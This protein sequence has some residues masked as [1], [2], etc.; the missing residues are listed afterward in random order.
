MSSC[1][2]DALERLHRFNPWFSPGG[3][4]PTATGIRGV[5]ATGYFSDESGWG[6]AGRGYV[7]ALQ[8]LRVPMAVHDVS[9]LTTNRSEDRSLGAT[10]T[11]AETDVNLVC[12]D[13]GQH[14]A[15]LSTVGESFFT[16]HYNIGAWAWELPRFPDSWYNRFAYY[17]EIW[18]GTSFIAGALAP[19]APVP[20]VRVPPAVS[21]PRGSR[22]RGR[23]RLG[24]N[25]REF[26]FLFVFDVHSHLARKNP[27][28]VIAA[29][30]AAF[31]NDRHVRLVL[32]SVNASADTEGFAELRA[33]GSDPRIEFHDGYWNARDMHDLVAACD[34]YVSLHRS[35]GTGLTIAEAMAAARPVIATDWSGNTDFCDASNSYPVAYTLTTVER[36]VGPYIAGETW[37]EP[38]VE[39][40]TALMRAIVADPE[41]AARRGR[42]AQQRIRDEYSEAAVARIVHSRLDVIGSRG[43]MGTLRRE[44]AAFVDG[45]RGL[46]GDILAIAARVIPAGEI[47]AVVSRGDSELLS[48]DRHQAWHFPEARPGVY[49]GHHPADSHAAI[50]AL[51]E[52]RA[53]GA[54]YL[55]LPGTAV[56]WLDHYAGFREHLDGRYRCAWRDASCIIYDLHSR[57]GVLT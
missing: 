6:T 31:P 33:S 30:R 56:W 7:R 14:F 21:A 29:F 17:D 50:E 3:E 47:V 38:D 11:A 40:A 23:A 12:V 46:V 54:G 9:A 49:A 22:D 8:Q 1:T 15:L 37:A 55:L 28:A 2:V 48:S 5:R 57:M 20:V 51:E 26:V 16:G 43:L 39:H 10:A 35:E 27:Q 18:V 4:T 19:I 52:A 42:T 45:Y 25:D 32:K 34:A 41:T 13:A 53:R 36:N 24:A 44:V